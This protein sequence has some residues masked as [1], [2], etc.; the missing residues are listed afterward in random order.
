VLGIDRATLYRWLKSGRLIR[1]PTGRRLAGGRAEYGVCVVQPA[2]APNLAALAVQPACNGAAE[3][4]PGRVLRIVIEVY[5]G[6]DK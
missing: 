2:A 6:V 5:L 3:A 4:V 1:C